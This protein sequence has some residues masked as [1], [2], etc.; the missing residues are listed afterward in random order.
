MAMSKQT[1]SLVS[2]LA[3]LGLGGAGAAVAY[4][5]VYRADE[6]EQAKKEADS[7]AFTFE[8]GDVK[9]LSVTAK[10][11]TTE[12]EK[13]G[14]GWKI[15]APVQARADRNAVDPIVDKMSDL[16]A[17]STIADDHKTAAEFGLDKPSFVAK[18]T[19][20]D[21]RTLELQ[22]G[23]ENSFDQSL[24]FAKAGDEHVYL[25]DSGLKYPLDKGLFDLRDKALVTHDDK[26]VETFGAET[27]GAAWAVERAGEGWH[28][29]APAADAADKAVVEGV[30][31]KVKGARAKAFLAENA[32]TGAAELKPYG[33]DRPAATATFGLGKD[34][35]K[36]TL[37][38]GEVEQNGA[39]KAYARLLEGGPLMEI[40]DALVK[41]LAKT[42]AEL[43]DKTVAGFDREQVRSL[44]IAPAEG[45]KLVVTRT[46]EKDAQGGETEKFAVDGATEKLKTWKLS[47][48]LYTLSSLKG[49]AIV[50]ENA[51]DLARFGLDRP[52][53]T[54]T[55]TGEG[56]AP[57]AKL[58]L[59]A[60]NGTKV[61]AAK[62]GATRV[63]EVEKTTVGDLPLKKEDVL[64]LPPP[65]PAPAPS[66]AA[67]EGT[68]PTAPP[69][70][71]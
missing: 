13:D 28:L 6:A 12:L 16:K 64:D 55:V 41:D 46:K 15:T 61:Y 65:A 43:Q 9:K 11:Q 5:G 27:S 51:K 18:L 48:A 67:T 56:G 31:A 14:E 30:L 23:L 59:G 2:M 44:E 37:Q 49:T 47:S 54:Y 7:Q 53:A 40:D 33:L 57:L 25:G 63:Y 3:L 17:K 38:I 58:L 45:A 26:D 19:L 71:G 35:A 21:G 22:V 34:R 29:T 8:K 32:P 70:G 50:E 52:T 69:S 39:K 36:K 60:T 20:A 68:P 66:A 42:L 10:G 24:Y 1:K 4:F 62:A